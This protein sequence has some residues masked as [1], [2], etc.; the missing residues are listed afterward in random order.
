MD[1]R[2]VKFAPSPKRPPFPNPCMPFRYM[3][4]LGL[5]SLL[6]ARFGL[7]APIAY[8]AQVVLSVRPTE[9]ERHA[10]VKFPFLPNMNLARTGRATPFAAFPYP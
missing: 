6:G 5:A 7:V 8:D 3:V 4:R 1:N 2:T 9:N 10:V